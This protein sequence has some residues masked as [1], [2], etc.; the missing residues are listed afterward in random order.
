VPKEVDSLAYDNSP[1]VVQE[2]DKERQQRE[3]KLKV[4]EMHVFLVRL[5]IEYENVWNSVVVKPSRNT[6]EA[7][8]EAVEDFLKSIIALPDRDLQRDYQISATVQDVAIGVSAVRKDEWTE[9]LR[10]LAQK[11]VLPRF[12]VRVND[13]PRI[14]QR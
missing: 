1:P 9:C 6:K 11:T 14:L 10:Y 7:I 12:C 3:E 4:G 8:F 2:L 13:P 5:E